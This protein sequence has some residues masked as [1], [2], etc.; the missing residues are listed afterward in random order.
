MRHGRLKLRL[1]AV[2]LAMLAA[3]TTHAADRKPL[4]LAVVRPEL[5]E[6]VKQLAEKRR[7]DGFEAIVSTASVPAALAAAPRRPDFLLLV[8]DDEP[9]QEKASWYLPA[10]RLKLYCWRS[11]QA[12]EFA[13][14][15]AWGDLDGDGIP[16]LPVGRIPARNRRQVELVVRKIIAFETQAPTSEDLQAPMWLGS[17]EYG[18]AIDAVAAGLGVTMVQ[19]KGPAWLRPWFVTGNP[20]DPFCGWP[21]DQPREFTKQMQHGGIAG[22]LMGHAAA[23]RFFSMTFRGRPVWYT[24]ADAAEEFGKGPPVPPMIFFACESA[25]FA[26][27]GGCQAK[28]LVLMPG[29]PVATI[30]ATTESHPL[31]NYYTGECLLAALGGKENRLGS[32]WFRAQQKAQRASDYLIEMVLRDAEGSL[33]KQINV[34]KLRR[35]QML[36]Y[37]ILGDPATRVRVP[38][39]L[40]ASFE[41]A[42]RG[43]RWKVTKPPRAVHL[44]V[45][46]R[47]AEPLVGVS[48]AK[49]AGADAAGKAFAAANSRFDFVALPAPAD[50]GTWD[51]TCD[52]PG[53]LRLVAS[54]P[55]VF[56]ATVLK[57]K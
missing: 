2:L 45:A 49:S 13:S 20:N 6:P 46:F 56:S 25:N 41:R 15:A 42:D 11:A 5:A 12:E 27:A 34:A 35:D 9:G 51:G 21:P 54:G 39:P 38:E 55:G 43:W 44:E 1:V 17:P 52:R 26:Q 3:A 47:S 48:K 7:R 10:K 29:G 24:A 37:A 32:I 30:G 36:M 19:N 40:A 16:D 14:D 28:S 23:D 50:G 8:G 22:V 53:W 33:E 57:L 18:T 31:T 4:W